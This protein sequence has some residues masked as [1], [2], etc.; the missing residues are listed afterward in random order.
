MEPAPN[1]GADVTISPMVHI[2]DGYNWN[3]KQGVKPAGRK[4]KDDD[5]AELHKAGLAK[6]YVIRGSLLLP[7]IRF[8]MPNTRS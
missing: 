4:I 3:K 1:G 7:P 6:E 2:Y 5:M 8:N